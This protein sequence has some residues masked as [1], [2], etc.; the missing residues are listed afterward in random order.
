MGGGGLAILLRAVGVG[1]GE[2]TDLNIDLRDCAIIIRKG[3]S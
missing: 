2:G 3:G 1:G